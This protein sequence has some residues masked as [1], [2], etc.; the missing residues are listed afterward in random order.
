MTPTWPSLGPPEGQSDLYFTCVFQHFMLRFFIVLRSLIWVLMGPNISPIWTPREGQRRPKSAFEIDPG[1]PFFGFDVGKPWKTDLG[2]IW[3]PSWG[4][5]AP[6]LG[7]FGVNLGPS[8]ARM[9]PSW[10]HVGA[11][12]GHLVAILGLSW[13]SWGHFGAIAS[14]QPQCCG[15]FA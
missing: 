6:I 2:P 4:S 7:V 10:G 8:W 13:P 1:T 15:P 9:G 14:T 5:L 12:L 11:V 3:P